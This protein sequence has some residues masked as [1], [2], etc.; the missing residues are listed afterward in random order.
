MS[1]PIEIDILT[2]D[3]VASANTLASLPPPAFTEIAFGGRSNVGKSSLIN[4]LV[5]RK[6]LVRTSSKPGATRGI[7]IFRTGWRIRSTEEG[8]EETRAEVDLVDL[9]GYGYAKRSKTERRSWGPLIEGFL[10]DR[11]GLRGL[12]VIVDVRRGPE[13]DDAQ[14]IEYLQSIDRR[15]LVVATKIDKIPRNQRKLEVQKIK[16]ALGV[17]V[18]PFSA[19]SA[20]GR[21]PLLRSLA[22]V[23]DILPAPTPTPAK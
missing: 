17:R 14:L 23:A 4:C 21:E 16:E 20:E 22:R 18:F 12:V 3:F 19:T 15:C 5:Q 10:R 8:V 13:D 9:P 1:T 2:A 7:N 11:P 6:K